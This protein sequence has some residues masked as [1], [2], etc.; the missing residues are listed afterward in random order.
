MTD[1]N[2]PCYE[3]WIVPGN[4]DAVLPDNSFATMRR[5]GWG[6]V[7]R[8]DPARSD[9]DGPYYACPGHKERD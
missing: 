6:Y 1:T 7:Q 8:P 5:L 9:G 3:G 4:C 2:I